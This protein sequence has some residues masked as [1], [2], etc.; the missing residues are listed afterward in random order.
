M[1]PTNSSRETGMVG[2]TRRP[3][4]VVLS[5]ML[6]RLHIGR[7]LLVA[8]EAGECRRASCLR[9]KHHVCPTH[10]QATRKQS[11]LGGVRGRDQGSL[12]DSSMSQSRGDRWYSTRMGQID[13]E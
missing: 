9:L 4:S 1:P 5:S 6:G 12:H 2:D 11:L 10:V 8:F 3:W 7:V 13:T